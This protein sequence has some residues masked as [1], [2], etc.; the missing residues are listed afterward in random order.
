MP[1][2]EFRCG[3]CG[4]EFERV[5]FGSDAGGVECPEC[6]SSETKRQLSVFSCSG[7]SKD[8]GSACSSPSSGF[9]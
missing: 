4:K 3:Q 5:V 2:Y 8:S 7:L 6:G 9:S 1:I